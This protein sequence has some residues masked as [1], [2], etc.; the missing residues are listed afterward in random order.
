MDAHKELKKIDGWTDRWRYMHKELN[1]GQM[2]GQY[3][4]F[5]QEW[6]DG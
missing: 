5:N 1:K 3:Q 4:E 2:D 6:R